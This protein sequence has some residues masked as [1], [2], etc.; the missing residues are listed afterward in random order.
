MSKQKL[1]TINVPDRIKTLRGSMDFVGL[2]LSVFYKKNPRT[3]LCLDGIRGVE[4]YTS[5]VYRAE[6]LERSRS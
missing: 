1:L 4:G 5:F 3:G 6:R 2:S